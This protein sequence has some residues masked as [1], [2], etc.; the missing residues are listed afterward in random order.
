MDTYIQEPANPTAPMYNQVVMLQLKANP[1]VWRVSPKYSVYIGNYRTQTPTAMSFDGLSLWHSG[2]WGDP[3]RT[4]LD[5]YKI[6]LPADW[7]SHLNA[8]SP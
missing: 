7:A 2:N 3:A 4:A 8:M 6:S 1:L 5:V